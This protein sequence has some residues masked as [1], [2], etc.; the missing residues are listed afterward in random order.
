MVG[1]AHARWAGAHEWCRVPAPAGAVIMWDQRT[2]HGSRPNKSHRAR[3]VLNLSR[4]SRST[5]CQAI[6]VSDVRPPFVT[7][8]AS[9]Q[10]HDDIPC[11]K[12]ADRNGCTNPFGSLACLLVESGAA[13]AACLYVFFG[14]LLRWGGRIKVTPSS[15]DGGGV[16]AAKPADAQSRRR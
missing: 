5:Q 13:G 2:P 1:H 7:L 9:K 16:F 6:V 4:S 11:D 12:P 15:A 10:P 14:R 8:L 3:A